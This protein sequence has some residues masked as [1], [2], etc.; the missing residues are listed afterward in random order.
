MTDP[1]LTE[2]P[3]AAVPD[4]G[5][6]LR[7]LVVDDD[8]TLREGCASVLQMDG[9]QVSSTGR[10]DEALDLVRRRKFDLV[11]VDLY[12]TPISGMEVLKA[13]V[14]A[15]KSVIVVIMTGNPTVASSIEALRAGAWDYLPKP[16][17]ASHLQVL[18]G[19]AA[20][21]SVA[22]REPREAI[23]PSSLLTPSSNGG[24]ESFS[25]LGVSPAFRKAV[26]LAQKVAGTD[27]SVMISGESG[28]GKEMIAQFIH[29]HSRRT[30]RKLVP[31]NCAALPDN[32]LESEMFGYR[33]GAFTGADRDKPGL[34]EVANGG[35]LFLDELTEMQLPLQAK[36]L[37]VLQDGVVRRLGS[38]TQDAVVDV[39]FISATNRDPQEAVQQGILREDLFYRLRVVPIKLPP[40]RKR[41]EDIPLLAD[42][43]LKRSWERHRASGALAPGFEPETMAFLQSRPWRGNVREL[44]NVI[45]HVAVIADATRPITPDDI[46]VYDDGPLEGGAAES[47]L[48]AS[49]MNDSF[50]V[51]KDNLIAH[52]EKEYLSRLTTRAGGNMSKAARLAGIDRTTLY[53]LM[54]KHGF[55]RDALSGAND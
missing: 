8:R 53:R 27:A 49:I 25:L 24:A 17:S 31:V 41:V 15:H 55:R 21:A 28:T 45:E 46:P 13:A 34:L 14:E 1:F 32:L 47:G 23:K 12:M 33:K 43:F 44:Q 48:P 51:A 22:S 30:Q 11:L 9:H 5:T 6:G 20:H 50:H 52:F 38:E 37:R 7:I 16:F 54:E 26:D 39:R 19:R 4:K 29:K 18:V 10:G 42:F 2:A 36:L 35:T 40:L 3:N